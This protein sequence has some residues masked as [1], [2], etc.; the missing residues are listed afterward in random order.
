MTPDFHCSPSSFGK[1]VHKANLSAEE[2][3]QTLHFFLVKFLMQKFVQKTNYSF[4]ADPKF[5]LWCLAW[6][7]SLTFSAVNALA[8]SFMKA[9]LTCLTLPR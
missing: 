7:F 1:K 3:H 8:L 5:P 9:N 4:T 2:Q 6:K